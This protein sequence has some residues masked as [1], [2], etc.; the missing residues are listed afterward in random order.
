MISKLL[1]LHNDVEA[2]FAYIDALVQNGGQ[3]EALQVIDEHSDRLLAENSAKVL[4]TLRGVIGPLGTSPPALE[5]LLELFQKAGDQSHLTEVNELLAHA[6]VQTGELT[7]ARDLYQGLAEQEPQNPMHMQNYQQVVSMM[8]GSSGSKLLSVEEGIV[9]VEE[10][11][12]TAPPVDQPYSPEVA[13]ALRAAL[14]D[15]ELFISYN[16]PDK[17][18]GPLMAV[19]PIAPTDVRLNQRLAALHTRSERFGDAAA[20][21]HTLASVYAQ[22]GLSEEASRYADLA[23]R[24]AERGATAPMR[25]PALS[26]TDATELPMAPW[27]LAP[28]DS[29]PEFAVQEE[30]EP[31][32]VDADQLADLPGAES[33]TSTS[34][35]DLSD[36]WEGALGAE[37]ADAPANSDQSVE[38][39]PVE[40]SVEEISAESSDAIAETIEE[41]HFYL[42]HS[43]VDQA[44]AA[45]AKLQAQTADYEQLAAIQT[46]IN[47]A[48]V[49][50]APQSEAVEEPSEVVSSEAETPAVNGA[51]IEPVPAP[52]PEPATPLNKLVADLDSSLGDGFL[53]QTATHEIEH[54]QEI[55]AHAATDPALVSHLEFM[56]GPK[57]SPKPGEKAADSGVL[58]EFV[59]D[60]EN[61]LG[62]GFLQQAPVVTPEPQETVPVFHPAPPAQPEPAVAQS[63]L[64]M[65]ASAVSG[66]APAPHTSV[67]PVAVPPAAA[68]SAA[69]VQPRRRH[70]HVPCLSAPRQWRCCIEA[71]HGCQRGS[72]R[73]V[74]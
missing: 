34:E 24:C 37:T 7:K 57:L 27:P 71:R 64:H 4:E 25:A 1:S 54:E 44:R 33:A 6:C 73:H 66:S 8:G 31:A 61:A 36:E 40:P 20:C 19:L 17:A 23:R 10:L 68:A 55:A 5:K 32:V 28:A 3:E 45:Y 69:N 41:I 52:E 59:A 2:M 9:L 22:A 49:P 21:C 67:P 56:S 51:G 11:E 65:A 29:M 12:A 47:A 70:P 58:G 63:E 43:M 15:T 18:L 13:N 35:I 72:R 50:A 74:W 42:E 14:T 16:M 30:S 60:L 39:S 48:S 38:E 62:D 53:P 26:A 46:E